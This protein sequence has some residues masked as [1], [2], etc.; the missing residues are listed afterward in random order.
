MWGKRQNSGGWSRSSDLWVMGP[1][2]C[3]LR[4]AASNWQ[5]VAARGRAAAG[6]PGPC[7]RVRP[8]PR[9]SAARPCMDG[10]VSADSAAAEAKGATGPERFAESPGSSSS[11]PM[12]PSRRQPRL[13]PWDGLGLGARRRVDVHDSA[14]AL[15]FAS[16][17]R[18]AVLCGYEHRAAV[19][20]R[21]GTVAVSDSR[22]ASFDGAV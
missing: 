17:I 13:P 3:P 5:P 18:Q 21:G 22:Q 7:M 19:P 11:G 1:T 4:H 8:A 14:P 15:R 16:R 10:Q 9:S 12:P 6:V 2:R 20:R